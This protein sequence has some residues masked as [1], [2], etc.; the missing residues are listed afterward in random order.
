MM[1][2]EIL[3]WAFGILVL[4][5]LIFILLA[6]DKL[7]SKTRD[8]AFYFGLGQLPE[9]KAPDFK[10][11]PKISEESENKFN[12]LIEI[13]KNPPKENSCLISIE[14]KIP[15][16]SGLSLNLY[17]NKVEIE[18]KRK[19]SFSPALKIESIQGFNPC[20]IHAENFLGFYL[21]PGKDKDIFKNKQKI[22]N[23]NLKITNNNIE[24][25]SKN[26]DYDKNFL[27]KTDD[28]FC[29]F[30]THST[31]ATFYKPWEWLTK[32][33]CETSELTLDND[34]MNLIEK[35]IGICGSKIEYE[36]VY[37]QGTYYGKENDWNYIEGLYYYTGSDP[38]VA[39]LFRS[40]AKD[41]KRL[42][43]SDGGLS[44]NKFKEVFDSK[45]YQD[46]AKTGIYFEN[47]YY[48]LKSEWKFVKTSFF[49]YDRWKYVNNDNEVPEIYKNKGILVN[50]K[51][52][53]FGPPREE[54]N[55][56][57]TI[58]EGEFNIED[59]PIDQ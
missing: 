42:W 7:L 50:K 29:F 39:F 48:G 12:N 8:A 52:R 3:G 13:F 59:V 58:Q 56:E 31:G 41:F 46:K 1:W 51:M 53:I 26:Y 28:N 45:S 18:D 14:N 49:S 6:P 44:E 38:R 36:N 25:K 30:L 2:G 40:E 22:Y 16:L 15:E 5:S 21:A 54:Q 11:D 20:I 33:G 24:Y 4:L 57:K 27:F 17:I 10:G 35:N 43:V 9:D 37:F 19:D 34:C 55:N 32:Y 23:S 47:N